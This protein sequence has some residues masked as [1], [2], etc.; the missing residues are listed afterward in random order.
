MINGRNGILGMD[1]RIGGEKGKIGIKI[2][3]RI[4][5]G[6]MNDVERKLIR[7]RKICEVE[8]KEDLKKRIEVIGKGMDEENI[9]EEGWK[10]EKRRMILWNNFKD[11][12]V[13][14][15]I[16]WREKRK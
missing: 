11:K 13:M 14:K 4:M 7:K 3:K 8:E 2:F 1:L 15:R 12:E 6:R 5:E 10:K 9:E 16:K